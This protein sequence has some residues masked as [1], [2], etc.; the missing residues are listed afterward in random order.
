MLY[1]INSGREKHTVVILGDRHARGCANKIN[2]KINKNFNV[3][4]STK[5][6]PDI[7]ILTVSAKGTIEKL[8]KNEVIVFLE[9]ALKMLGRI[10]L[11]KG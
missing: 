10:I 4:G 3:T 9:E 2:D 8:T 5:Q 7:P 6:E 11:K 1:N